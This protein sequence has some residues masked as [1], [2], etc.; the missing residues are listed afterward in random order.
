[1]PSNHEMIFCFFFPFYCYLSL[2]LSL[3]LENWVCV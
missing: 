1:M 3:S 2:P